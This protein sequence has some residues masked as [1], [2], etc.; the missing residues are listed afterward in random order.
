MQIKIA[1]ATAFFIGCGAASSAQTVQTDGCTLR[2]FFPNNI[3]TTTS[4]QNEQIIAFIGGTS[5]D[6]F[7]V[8]GF[9]SDVGASADNARLSERRAARVGNV[10][11]TA[12]YRFQPVPLGEAG[13]DA[14]ARRAEIYRD[15][16]AAAVLPS[17]PTTIATGF[18]GAAAPG[19]GL[20]C[21]APLLLIP[22]ALSSGGG[23]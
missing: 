8:R 14:F 7:V 12:G 13:P 19:C 11:S 6:A 15:D 3:S 2:V 5:S 23:T 9:A 10:V 4:E 17:A 21:L 1:I 22:F 20:I 16:C 18:S